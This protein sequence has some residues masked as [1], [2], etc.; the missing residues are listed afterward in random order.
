M[1][2]DLNSMRSAFR[3]SAEKQAKASVTLEKIMEVEG[4]DVS[5]EELAAEY[6]SLAKQYE[7][8]VEKIK[9]MVPE[10]EIKGSIKSRKAVKIIVD[11]AVAVAPK[12][13]EA[14]SEE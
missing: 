1:G 12:K 5:E 11:S 7:M 14:S 4:I 3:P 8:E 10:D 9:S 13:E 6:E 2:G